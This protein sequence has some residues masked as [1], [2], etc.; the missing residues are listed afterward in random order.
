MR[1]PWPILIVALVL[2]TL[3]AL[4]YFVAADAASPLFRVT[5]VFAK[6]LQFI[7]PVGALAFFDRGSLW[8][9]R[10]STRG[11]SPGVALG[12]LT[13]IAIAVAHLVLFRHGSALRD[14]S[15]AIRGKLAGFGLNSE[16]RFIILGVFYSVVH[17]FLEEYYWRWFVYAALRT[18]CSRLSAIFIS[19]L[20][21]AA[22]HFVV[23]HVYF[24][25]QTWSA[26]LPFSLAVAIGGAC[27]AWLYERTGSL[28]G[29]WI[30]HALADAALM[31][32]GFDLL[33]R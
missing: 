4:A 17:S 23:L 19:S 31:A 7:L 15:E 16:G 3:A 5:Y 30:A 8:S 18:K 14:P 9:V 33:Y 28:A 21:F 1:I 12:L 27:W 26:T 13:F 6:A 32:I 11:I 2:P 10:L 24:P 20:G 29:P 25:T 22:H